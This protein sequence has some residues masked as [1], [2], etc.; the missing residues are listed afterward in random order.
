MFDCA[1]QKQL[2]AKD[3]EI[4]LV[5]LDQTTL[6]TLLH[7]WEVWARDDQ[8]PP[9]DADWRT[10]L[11][12]GGRGAG[13]TRSGAEWVRAQALGLAPFASEPVARIAL[14]GETYHDARAV[15]VEGVSGL[16]A[17]HREAERPTYYASRGELV[18]PNGAIAQLFSAEDPDGLRGPQFGAAWCDEIA[19]WRRGEETWDMLQFGLRLGSGPRAVVTTTPRANS[20][21]KALLADPAVAVS[22]A[23]TQDNAANLAGTFLAEMER[24]YAGTQLGRQELDGELIDE[25]KGTLWQR[26]WIDEHRVPFGPELRRIVVGVDPPVTTGEN[27]DACGIV[28]A[29]IDEGER[30]YVL[31][32]ATAQGLAPNEWARAA[33]EAYRTYQ[34]D[35]I[36][37]EVNQGGDLVETVIRNVDR[38]A[39]ITKVHAT[40][41]KWL[42]AE[43]VAALYAEGRVSHVGVHDALEAE[44]LMFGGDGRAAGKSPDRLDALVWAITDLMQD[45][46]V[47][48]EPRLRLV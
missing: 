14:V 21:L 17:V 15:M 24:R 26:A 19:K 38:S 40:R 48:P 46:V 33:L 1:K 39:A 41:G 20:M 13:K 4:E 32:D 22:R 35:R 30:C 11:I 7:D 10:W 34:A 2:T 42:R 6:E 8:L 3:V 12:L 44:M 5:G 27:A 43:P 25:L 45:H 16:L 31:A 23:R 9:M 28:V 47:S 36:V 29:G 37:A 18:W